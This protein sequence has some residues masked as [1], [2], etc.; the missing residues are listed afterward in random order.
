MLVNIGVSAPELK[1]K[2]EEYQAKILG[3]AAKP[4]EIGG[5]TWHRLTLHPMAPPITWGT[6]GKYFIVG[7]GQGSVEGILERAY[8]DPPKWLVDLRKRLPVERESTI[9]YINLKTIIDTVAPLAGPQAVAAMNALGLQSVTSLASVTGLEA[10]GFVN[11]TLLGFEGQPEG[12]LSLAAGEPLSAD[13]LAAIPRDATMAAALRLDPDQVL[14]T[15]ASVVAKI[16]PQARGEME[17]GLADFARETGMDLRNDLLRP[18]GDVW[19]VYNSPSEGGLIF[20]GL[21][22]VA[23]VD[24]AARMAETHRKLQT[25]IQAVIQEQAGRRRGPRIQKTEFGGHEIYVFDAGED[26]F[27]VAP[28]WCFTDQ[29]VVLSL[30]PQNIRAYLA[31]GDDFQSLADVPEVATLLESEHRPMMVSYVDSR[32]MFDILYPFVQMGLQMAVTQMQR[33]GIDID[34]SLLPSA[35]AIGK[36]LRPTVAAVRRTDAGLEAV[37]FQTLPGGNVGTSG[38]LA[39]ALLLPAVQ[40]AREA[41]RRTQSSNNMKMIGLALHNYH[42]TY[43]HFPAAYTVDDEGKPLLSWRVH[44][45]PFLEAAPLYEQFHLDEPWDN[46]HNKKLIAQ[47]PEVYRCPNGPPAGSGK[48]SYLGVA[49]ERGI[50]R[51]KDPVRF[52]DIRDGTSNTIAT[53]EANLQSAVIWT[54]P[55]DFVPD[56]DD[57]AKGLRGLRPGGFNAG[58]ADGSVRFLSETIDPETLKALFTRDGGEAIDFSRLNARSRRRGRFMTAPAPVAVLSPP[59]AVE[60]VP[61]ERRAPSV[62]GLITLDGQPVEGATVLFTPMEPGGQAAK[63]VTDASGRFVVKP[64]EAGGSVVPGTYRVSIKKT[65][66]EDGDEAKHL[67]PQ[68]YAEP[69]TSA[70]AVEIAGGTNEIS[71]DLRSD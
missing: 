67:L 30:F 47:M 54:K 64:A 63:G 20:S 2:L 19:C 23:K 59:A 5:D 35:A 14:E 53:V 55:D 10:D 7:V 70:L 51:G 26:E 69:T 11:K 29:E 42:D 16:D 9:S 57:P 58:F 49:G 17:E 60:S 22:A 33:E 40:S 15:I 71:F 12:I 24:D 27:P 48:T 61:M 25:L 43:K 41:A 37:S 56:P 50:F 1:K 62:S 8:T 68:K 4:V 66:A 13:A 31:R 65:V 34:L 52:A 38:P 39:V 6:K 46:E 45:L 32:A 21:T 18:L 28:S 44:I 3:G 36:H